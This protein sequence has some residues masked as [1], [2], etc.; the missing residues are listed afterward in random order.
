MLHISALGSLSVLSACGEVA[1]SMPLR[2]AS[3]LGERVAAAA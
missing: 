3:K 2:R 1:F